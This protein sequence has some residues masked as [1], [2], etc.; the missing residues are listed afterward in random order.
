MH[1]NESMALLKVIVFPVIDYLQ[2]FMK[3]L[4][5]HND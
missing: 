2:Q 1:I 5:A 4:N 3:H